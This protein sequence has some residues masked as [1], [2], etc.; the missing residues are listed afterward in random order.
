M[1]LYRFDN[2]DAYPVLE[3][4]T[5]A[6]GP[7][8]IRVDRESGASCLRLEA[9]RHKRDPAEVVIALALPW[10]SIGGDLQQFLL[11]VDG[12]ASGCRLTL[13]A[14]DAVG[15][16]F[17]YEFGAVDFAG[18]RTCKADARTP[19]KPRGMQRGMAEAAICFPLQLHRLSLSMGA[20]CSAVNVAFRNLV[21]TGDVHDAPSG[22][23]RDDA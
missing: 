7:V 14:A 4:L 2:T 16:P 8:T 1:L 18:W 11:D 12:D 19:S 23:A 20:D 5:S 6:R 10:R 17:F 21:V 15:N 3:S 13:E 22:I 9:K